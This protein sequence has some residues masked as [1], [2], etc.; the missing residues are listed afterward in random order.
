MRIL[1]V[2]DDGI[3]APGLKILERAAKTL[4]KD[5]WVVAPETEQSAASHSLTLHR[6]LRLR[7]ISRRRFAVDGTPT[8]CVYL[9]FN[10]VLADGPPDLVLSGVNRGSNVGEDVTYSGTIAAAMEATLLGA[11]AVALSQFYG[12]G[13][14][15]KWTTAERWTPKVVRAL[16]R[17]GWPSNVLINVN[18]PDV[19]ADHVAGMRACRQGVHEVGDTFEERID[20]R[21]GSYYWVGMAR[22]ENQRGERGTDLR[23]IN[24]GYVSVTPLH[25]DL[26][27]QPSMKDMREALS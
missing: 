14:R 25:L 16:L 8:D 21:G 24:D 23:A 18:F 7:R 1:L 4:S 13:Q 9:A 5:I 22:E 11:P 17:Q 20:P 19:S 26:T 3:L 10:K 27:H 2:N 6:P 15:I 12:D